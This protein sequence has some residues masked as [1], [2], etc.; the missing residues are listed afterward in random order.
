[1]GNATTGTDCTESVPLQ[2]KHDACKRKN[3]CLGQRLPSVAY[4]VPFHENISSPLISNS[5]TTAVISRE[6]TKIL[7][8]SWL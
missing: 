3:G 7:L 4:D 2:Q 6:K 8:G 1:M 5:A